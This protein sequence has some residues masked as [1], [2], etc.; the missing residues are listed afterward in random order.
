MTHLGILAMAEQRHG[1]TLLYTLS[2]I[3][4]LRQLPTERF[5]FTIFAARDNHEYDRL[6]LPI[7][8]L[9][10]TAAL[11][12]R[13]LAGGDLFSQC[14]A[15]IAPVYSMRLMASR[16]PFAFTLH[17]LQEKHFPQHFGR[18]TRLWRELANRLLTRRAR[19]IICESDF[20]RRDILDHYAVPA[21]KIAVTPAPPLSQLRGDLVDAGRRAQVRERYGLPARYVFYPAQF[22]PHK[23]HF[24]LVEAFASIAAEFPDCGLVLTGKSRDEYERVFRRVRALSIQSRVRHIGYVASEDLAALYA[25]ATVVALPTLFESISIP[26]YEAFSMGTA[27]CAS[28]V[29]ALPE[30]IGDAGLLFDPLSVDDIAA[31]IA[32]LLRDPTLR[33]TLVQRG[34]ARMRSVTHGAYA[35]RLGALIDA[36]SGARPADAA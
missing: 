5:R 31:K 1:G 7:V 6:G 30:Q 14:D 32:Q 12:L 10:S 34:H 9:P 15:V 21:G 3:E 25:G 2:M 18:T 19:W 24:R 29:V 4:A 11:V 33:Q 26:V 17:D 13:R 23:N 22:W 16:R 36:M 20:V 35:A 27:V 28:R 8:R